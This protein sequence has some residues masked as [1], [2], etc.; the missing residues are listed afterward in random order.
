MFNIFDELNFMMQI[1]YLFAIGTKDFVQCSSPQIE[2]QAIEMFYLFE[3]FIEFHK[4]AS[5]E[6]R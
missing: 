5:F 4:F 3:V 1:K 2:F 6:I